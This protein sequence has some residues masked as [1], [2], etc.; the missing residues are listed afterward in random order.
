MVTRT[1]TI[2]RVGLMI[3]ALALGTSLHLARGTERPVSGAA[4]HRIV[5]PAANHG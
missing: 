2:G 3:I 4:F 1:G 5:A